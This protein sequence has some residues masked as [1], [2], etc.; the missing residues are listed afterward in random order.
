MPK[1]ITAAPTPLDDIDYAK[2]AL[3]LGLLR[4]AR[5]RLRCLSCAPQK[6]HGRNRQRRRDDGHT[7]R[8][9]R[10]ETVQG[11]KTG[12]QPNGTESDEKQRACRLPAIASAE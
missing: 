8:A 5:G 9:Y 6:P 7:A 12:P 3:S 10:I 2:N 11:G 1:R 4:A